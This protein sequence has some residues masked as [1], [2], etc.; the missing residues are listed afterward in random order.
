MNDQ[1][2]SV[3]AQNCKII[4]ENGIVTLRGWVASQAEKDAIESRAKAIVG[5]TQVTNLLDVQP[6]WSRRT[7]AVH[8]RI[9]RLAGR[10]C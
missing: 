4:T 10:S 8:E 7:F 1:T 3:N 5:V 9:S 6:K 2:M